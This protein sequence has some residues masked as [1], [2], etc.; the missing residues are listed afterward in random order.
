M[1]S[2]KMLKNYICA[3]DIGS[4]KISACVAEVRKKSITNIFFESAPLKSIKRGTIVDS[5]GL[6]GSISRLLKNLKAKSGINIKFIY[7]DLSG[8][9]ITTKHS[10]AIIPLAERGNKVITLSDIQKVNEQG[11]ILGSS[12]EEEIIHRIPYSYTVDSSANI[13]NPLGLY[14]HRL[15]VDLYLV[16]GKLSSIQTLTRV[17]NQAG[18]EIKDLYFTGLATSKAICNEELKEGVNILCDIGSDI[19]ELLIFKDGR[20]KG[21][22]IL[23][24]GGGDLTLEISQGLNIPFDLAEDVKRSYAS[25]GDYTRITEDKE[26]LVKKSNFYKPIKQRWVCELTTSKTMSICNTI[27]DT[28]QNLVP[29]DKINNFITSGRTVLLEGFIEM[30]ENSLGIS[31]RLARI[32]NPEIISLVSKHPDLSGQKYLSYITALGIIC[33]AVSDEQPQ[34]ISSYQPIHNPLVKAINKVKEIYQE[35]F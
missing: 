25:I 35:Y 31:V 3:L 33:Q 26:I 32:M 5:I 24:L 9:D 8:Q 27:K 15:E 23:A 19:T 1:R 7:T 29:T 12:L 6:S 22:E 18:F 11:R 13:V 2:F 10:R 16:C 20:L 17:V 28:V 30:L 34:L 14:S 21:I 4:S